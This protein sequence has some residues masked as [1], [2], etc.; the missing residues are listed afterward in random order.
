MSDELYMR[1]CLELAS[2]GESYAAPN[3]MVG[4]VIA[5]DG[6]IIGEG[7]HRRC[8]GPHAEVN[9]V[10]SVTD[11][12]LLERSTLYV[13]LEPCSHWGKT[14][15]CADMIIESKIPKVV[16]GMVDPFAKVCGE[17]IRKLKGAG[18]DVTVGVLEEE[19]RFL[20]RKFITFHEKKRPY[21]TLKWAQTIDGYLDN[22]RDAEIPA[23]W[24]TGPICRKLVHRMRTTH[25]GILA[26]T[27]TIIRDNP[28]FTAREWSGRQPLR[29][30]LDR[31]LRL[32]KSSNVFND[33]AETVLF[34]YDDNLP[35]AEKLFSGIAITGWIRGKDDITQV[36]DG[37]YKMNIQ[38]L[39]VEGGAEL[40]RTLIS[41]N[42][43]DEA[44][45]FVSQLSVRDLAGGLD[46]DPTG[47]KAPDLPD[48]V[49]GREIIDG[50]TL[51]TIYNRN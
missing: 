38:S 50:S 46:T 6:R 26:G 31:R 7:Y 42:L 33:K 35:G 11:K 37:L 39:F 1:R 40:F 43:W 44:K 5:H 30:V 49:C 20:N 28:S 48:R 29:V 45:V 19:C 4:S 41:S 16:V 13:N 32:N 10:N 22:N 23:T 18:V 25:M 47:I 14:P 9:A 8:G 36:M 27:N 3:P 21:I 24:M 51:L 17:G 15:P 2:L 34:T 12:E